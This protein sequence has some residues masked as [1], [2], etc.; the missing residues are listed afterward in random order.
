KYTKEIMLVLITAIVVSVISVSATIY[1]NA[2]NITFVPNNTNWNVSNTN[3]ALNDLYSYANSGDATASNILV[4]KTALVNGK[5]I[6]GTMEDR[7]TL[8]WNPTTSTTY[9][10]EPGYYSGGTL[11]SSGAYNAGY[12]AGTTSAQVYSLGTGT[13]FD[14]KSK[15]PD[16]YANLTADNFIF[17]IKIINNKVCPGGTGTYGCTNVNGNIT[18]NYNSSTGLLTISWPTGMYRHDNLGEFY[19]STPYAYTVYVVIGNIKAI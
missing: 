16:D 15:F 2:E 5:L 10:V 4:G 6:T 9:T 14:I 8:N 11:N 13:S 12:N 3:T 1:F 19:Y 18:K 17:E 7:G